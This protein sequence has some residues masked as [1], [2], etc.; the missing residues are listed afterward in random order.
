MMK[1]TAIVAVL[2][3]LV[4]VSGCGS[5]GGYTPQ[6]ASLPSRLTVNPDDGPKLFPV[7]EGNQWVYSVETVL[8]AGGQTQ[9]GRNDV[10]MRITR[11]EDTPQ[12]KR[13]NL[14][15]IVNDQV[16]DRQVWLIGRE[17]ILQVSAGR[18]QQRPL[19]PPQPIVPFPLEKGREWTWEGTGPRPTGDVGPM[20]VTIR[21]VGEELADMEE[22]QA[23]ALALETRTRWT[24]PDNQPGEAIQ[25]SWW[26]PGQG[27]IRLRQEVAT[28]DQ[29]ALQIL[30][31]RSFTGR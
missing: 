9:S 31:L 4:L 26:V 19:T 13:V 20:R 30:R 21:N 15:L 12:G 24:Q 8:E 23:F 29:R 5:N 2:A 22:G 11:V 17:G 25:K 27:I 1:P 18:D 7:A 28:R 3:G 14:E 16:S 6:K 10:T